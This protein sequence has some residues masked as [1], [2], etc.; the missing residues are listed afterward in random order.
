MP[1][2]REQPEFE[3]PRAAD[4]T[5]ALDST[6]AEVTDS[7]L[8]NPVDSTG[9]LAAPAA[10]AVGETG[11]Q[12]LEGE[13]LVDPDA[14]TSMENDPISSG[15]MP[16]V[17]AP[18]AERPARDPQKIPTMPIPREP[19]TP[20]PKQTLPG[21]GGLDPNP[22]FT[23]PHDQ[24]T[25]R[26][27]ALQIEPTQ[28]HIVPFEHTLVHVPEDHRN[29][30]SN[31]PPP[32][33]HAGQNVPAPGYQQRYQPAS[34]YTQPGVTQPARPQGAN[35]P[36]SP[37]RY[38][39]APG[40]GRPQQP[41]PARRARRRRSI[42]GCSP[43]CVVVFAGLIA[44]FCG[45][46]TLIGL[47]LTAT[48]G[49]Q[50]EQELQAQVAQFDDYTNFASTFYY[51]RHGQLLY[52]DFNEGRR[53]NV[54]FEDFPDYLIAATVATEDDTFWTNPG[55]EAE[56]TI[57]AFLQF[58]GLV[59][60]DS[61]GSTITQQ[62]VRNVLFDSVYRS[63][64]SVQ[65]KAEEIM[66]AF[67]LTQQQSKEETLTLYLNEIYYGNLSY[68]AEAAARTF[69]DKSV[70]EL[71]LGE[72][73]LL[74]GLPQAPANL[75]PL[76]PDPAVQAAV[77]LRWR[78]VLD[79]M[80]VEGYITDAER[81]AALTEG[82]TYRPTGVSLQ[83]PHF[84]VFARNELETLMTDLGVSPEEIAQGGWRVYTTLDLDLLESIQTTAQNQVA[85]LRANNVTNA[86]VVVTQPV[87]GQ[88][89]AMLGSVDYNND[90]IDGRVNV[91]I[92]PRQPGSTMKPFTYAAAI[93]LGMTPGDVIWDTPTDI[94]SPGDP[95]GVYSPVNYD[96]TFHG[97]VRMRDALANS[98][99]VPAV[100]T[101]REMGVDSLIQMMRRFGVNSLSD[102]PGRYG[103]SLTLGGGELTLLELTRAYSVFANGG[104]FVPTTA[105]LC[106]LD[107]NDNIIYEYEGGCPRGTPT[108][109]TQQRIGLGT[110]VLDPRVAYLMTD[111]MA[112][113]AARTPAMGSDGPL[114]TGSLFTAVKTGTTNDIRDNWTVGY[115]RNV[116]VGVWV[117]NSDGSPMVNSSGL[118]GAAPIW[119][120]V[121]LGIYNNPRFLE[122]L[123]VEG[124]PRPDRLDQPS[125]MT[126]RQLCRL[127]AMRDPVE[128]CGASTQELFLLTPAGIPDG[129]GGLIYPPPNTE[130]NEPPATGP[131][132]R[133]VEP[134]IYRVWVQ[135]VPPN[136]AN[137]IS[138]AP[139]G[140]VSPP[141]PLY[142]QVP[143]ESLGSAVGARE[144]LFIGPPP[145]PDDAARAEQYARNT[146]YAFLPTITCNSELLSASSGRPAVVTAFI[147]EPSNGAVVRGNVPVM[148]TANFGPGQAQYYKI[149]LNGPQ[150]GNRWVTMGQTHS[151]PVINGQLEFLNAEGLAPGTYQMQLV[152]IG[153]DSNWVQDPFQVTF[154]VAR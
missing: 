81:R 102:E 144:Q 12:A 10:R 46:L 87:T 82:L 98:Y 43:G 83:A 142:C 138:F 39:A 7:D 27:P 29:R 137:A 80:V 20:D 89:L 139:L 148:G 118:T 6:N 128:N 136:I 149:E 99:N 76:N 125:G 63:T 9:A 95:G 129:N 60:G 93:E 31:P 52:E 58:V 116:A 107:S 67:L 119:N 68:G 48:L 32:P 74:A 141:A 147:S 140:Q 14:A 70:G 113:N 79:R 105:I 115:N 114:N 1:E 25:Q 133:E 41:L 135:P 124:S 151:Q 94:P 24:G 111:I 36:P 64:R 100:Q 19:G 37:P 121:I 71:T 126:P 108:P 104:S 28:P 54:R 59:E 146:G 96:R 34:Q 92:S 69:F 21:S 106:V 88:I 4:D 132:L 2:E 66:L 65:R 75:D 50:L 72:A 57:R 145:F 11:N 78:T 61:G 101:L 38:P 47:V 120:D 55:F 40:A 44:T 3:L 17:D 154:T 5:D 8:A 134:D 15:Q 103:L 35:Y 152:V 42:L 130:S 131:W 91:T 13:A 51:D 18:E 109:T 84:T 77:D 117:G 112:D 16:A 97:P 53:T 110:Q 122:N 150:F 86:A 85:A 49:A 56:A 143:Q 153:P 90:A 22:D 73:A 26:N 30:R 127:S 45:G 62:L 33:Q 23:V 123:L